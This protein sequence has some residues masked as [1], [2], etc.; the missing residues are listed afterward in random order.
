MR[1]YDVS[2]IEYTYDEV[3]GCIIA[4]NNAGEALRLMREVLTDEE[5]PE[6]QLPSD[7]FCHVTFLCNCDYPTPKILMT[8]FWE[9]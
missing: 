6:L 3:L 9:A 2:R 7:F 8:D 4:A 1:L 5:F